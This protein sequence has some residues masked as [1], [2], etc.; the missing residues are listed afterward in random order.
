MTYTITFKDL[1]AVM[2][3][4]TYADPSAF[5]ADYARFSPE[6]FL[7]EMADDEITPEIQAAY[8]ASLKSDPHTLC[9][10]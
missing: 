8:E 7:V 1:P 2:S 5:I 10:L 6:L 4:K 9:N 3:G